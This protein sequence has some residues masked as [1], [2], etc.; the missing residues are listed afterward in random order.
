MRYS[1]KSAPPPGGDP[2]QFV[3]SDSGVDRMGDVIEATGWQ[4]SNFKSHPIA[5]FN[6]DPDQVIGKWADVRI[7]GGQLVGNLE[8]AEAGT[9]PLVDTVRALHEQKILR[10]VSVGFRPLKKEP[11]GKDADEFWGPFKFLK[12]ELL[13]CSLVSV[14]ANPRA[15][16]TAKSLNLPSDLMAELFRKT[17]EPHR[18]ITPSLAKPPLA[19]RQTPTMKTLSERIEDAQVELVTLKDQLTA[20]TNASDEPDESQQAQ[21]DELT[22][23]IE[24]KTKS[25]D[26]LIKAEQGLATAKPPAPA[27]QRQIVVPPTRC[28]PRD[29]IVRAMAVHFVAKMTGRQLD[30]VLRERYPNDEATGMVLRAAVAPAQ[31]TVAGWAAELVGTAIADFLNQ[32]AIVSIYPR[33]AAKGPKFTFGRNGVIK[34]PAR[35]ATP[36]INGSFVGEG[37]PIPVR[38]L[39]LSAITLTPKKM[40]V[41][42]EFT[43]EMGLHS[44][45]AIEGVIRQAMNEDT[46]EAIDTV[47]IDTVAA[48]AIRPAGIRN[49]ISGLTPSA[50]A[51]RFEKIAADIQTLMAPIIA[52]RGG[53]D[54]VLLTNPAQ[55]L[56]MDWAV[57]PAGTFVFADG[58]SPGMRGL[59]IISS[60]TVPAGMLI[61]IDAAD[62]ASV[63]GDTPEFDVSDVA[64]I[65]EEDT[66]PL[67]IGTAGAPATI[68]APTR[69]LWQTAS[70][71]IRMLLDMN[72]SMRRTGMVTWMTGV[73][74]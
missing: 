18:P 49:G 4:L 32:L 59:S 19:T 65:H 63:T 34:V 1:V 15:L 35:A 5:L 47:L 66:T 43:R 60:T 56:A 45:P 61:M 2:N 36:K 52:N 51:T 30:E 33:L 21:I 23:R 68:A 22:A 29:H 67:P 14:P 62:F 38:K 41:I 31:T 55:S 8:L 64:T 69:S 44:T 58:G 16:S 72:W 10:A 46:A 13:E 24:Q 37:Q 54:L 7:A 48:D 50:A 39:G 57:T 42:S 73:T 25:R 26:S 6:H 12:S 27:V 3:M 71:G 17:A 74:W 70:I 11:L 53:R 20:I 9:S 28:E 40:A